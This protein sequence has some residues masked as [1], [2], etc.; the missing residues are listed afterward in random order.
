MLEVCRCP[1]ACMTGGG[2]HA[3]LLDQSVII[4]RKSERLPLH[5]AAGKELYLI[6]GIDML[7]HSTLP[8]RRNTALQYSPPGA[9]EA[10]SPGAFCMTA[11]AQLNPLQAH[12]PYFCTQPLPAAWDHLGQTCFAQSG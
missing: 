9:S 12:N 2:Q 8:E 11:G 1:L 10:A 6:P 5:S 7:N 3:S 4:W